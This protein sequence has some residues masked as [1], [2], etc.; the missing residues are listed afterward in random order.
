MT[1]SSRKKILMGIS[2]LIMVYSLWTGWESYV[3]IQSIVAEGFIVS[4]NISIVVNYFVEGGLKY[5]VV[6]IILF[7]YSLP[8]KF[9]QETEVE[10]TSGVEETVEIVEEKEPVIEEN[11]LDEWEVAD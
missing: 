4:E 10:S 2:I 8:N 1:D 11:L 5:L 6:G 7:L 3:Y 9:P